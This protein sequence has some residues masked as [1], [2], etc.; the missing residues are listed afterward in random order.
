M[1]TNKKRTLKNK[2]KIQR[3]QKGGYSAADYGQFVWGTNQMNNPQQGNVIMVAN[4]PSIQIQ[5]GG[6][7]NKALIGSMLSD[8]VPPYIESQSVIHTTPAV[9]NT[10]PPVTGG[11]RKTFY[12]RKR[13]Q[14]HSKKKI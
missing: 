10:T 6:D 14:T 12:K 9:A 3:K 7:G 13:R 1:R 2:N 4:D 5:K 11:K 8:S